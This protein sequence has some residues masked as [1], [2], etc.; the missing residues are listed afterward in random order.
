M[1]TLVTALAI[2]TLALVLPQ[3]ADAQITDV[4]VRQINEIHPDSIQALLDA[5]DALTEADMIQRIF[6]GA[7]VA[8]GDTVRVGVVVLSNP[9][10]SGLST[11]D[12]DTGLPSRIHIFVRD[13]ASVSMGNAGMGIQIVDGNYQTTGTLGLEVGDVI[14]LIA[15]ATPFN[16]TMQLAPISYN[17]LDKYDVLGFPA[18]IMEPDVVTTSDIN[19]AVGS[20]DGL[21]ANWANFEQYRQ[22]YVRLEGVTIAARDI[23]SD[24]PAFYITSDGGTTGILNRDM[25]L[26]F[27]NDRAGSYPDFNVRDANDDF[28]PPPPGSVVNIQGFL[29]L[30]DFDSF[31]RATPFIMMISPFEDDDI[32]VIVGP[33]IISNIAR[34]AVPDANAIDVT[35][36]V[37]ADP[38]RSLSTVELKFFTTASAD[39]QTVAAGTPTGDT[40]PFT[41]PAAGDGEYVTFWIVATDDQGASSRSDDQVYLV[42]ADGIDEIADIQTTADGDEGPSP[43]VGATV[44]TSISAVVQ[45]DGATTGVYALQD[46]DTLGPWS[47]IEVRTFKSGSPMPALGDRVTIA[48]ALITERFNLTVLDSLVVTID[49]SGSP[50]PY[51]LVTTDVLQDFAIAEAHEGMLL[52]F[53]DV[54]IVSD[55]VNNFGEWSFSSDGTPGNVVIVDDQSSEIDLKYGIDNLEPGD[56][57]T[58]IQGLHSYTFSEYKLFPMT[59][60]DIGDINV[61]VEEVV[62]VDGFVLSQN[63]PNPFAANTTIVVT[64]PASANVELAVFDVLGR[65]VATILNDA[66]PAG[67]HV[68]EFD[69][70]GLAS[71]LYMYRL[72]ADG[73][74]LVRTMTVVR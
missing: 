58:Y 47:G 5:G 31:G 56:V 67:E 73:K 33:P 68:V 24:R 34:P 28:V 70:S 13:T 9:R 4:T 16:E 61:G 36:D 52:R 37:A 14:E 54:T 44:T 49:G 40:F 38:A 21:Q 2:V 8:R 41:I 46:D 32:E 71:G 17:L 18:S 43:F 25:S 64:T 57:V 29:V 60:S 12:S 26:R 66:L 69:R 53:E 11:P 39:T 50:L 74:S 20:G 42:L 22:S 48:E 7:T 15:T 35:A 55:S 51:K 1:K 3:Q 19:R 23:S 27:R 10:N 59:T 6:D 30:Y 65:R 45:T 72:T 62:E 63:Y